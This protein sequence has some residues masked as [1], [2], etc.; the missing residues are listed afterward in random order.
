MEDVPYERG[1]EFGDDGADRVLEAGGPGPVRH[2]PADDGLGLFWGSGGF[3]ALVCVRLGGWL[4]LGFR[5]R[6]WRRRR[7]R[8]SGF[9]ICK[10]GRVGVI[11]FGERFGGR[12]GEARERGGWVWNDESGSPSEELR[13]REESHRPSCSSL[14]CSSAQ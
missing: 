14:Q 1:V 8:R 2:H 5:G 3:L 13:I 7:R 4:V 11:S 6:G 10:G 12:G 9:G